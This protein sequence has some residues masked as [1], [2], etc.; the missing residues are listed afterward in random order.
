MIIGVNSELVSSK[1]EI[2]EAGTS[3]LL[4]TKS[5]YIGACYRAKIDDTETLQAIDRS[6][7]RINCDKSSV[8][9]GGDFNLPGWDW[10]NNCIKSKSPFPGIHQHFAEIIDDHGLPQIVTEPTRSSNTLDLLITN[11]LVR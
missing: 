7:Q 9:L 8:L 1:E 2:L 10:A 4:W 5:L 6:L 3:E 11:L